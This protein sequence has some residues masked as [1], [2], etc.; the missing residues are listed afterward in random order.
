[1]FSFNQSLEN[2]D[3]SAVQICVDLFKSA[4]VFN[5]AISNWNTVSNVTILTMY[6][7]FRGANSFNQATSGLEYLRGNKHD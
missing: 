5:Q 4:S 3:I 7:L 2:W 1:M 6:H